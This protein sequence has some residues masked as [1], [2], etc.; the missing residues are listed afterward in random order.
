MEALSE[1][2]IDNKKLGFFSYVFNFDSENKDMILNMFQ[3]TFIALPF[4][5]LV[6]K[7][8]NYFTPEEDEEKKS[9]EI[10][11]EL[12]LT[13]TALLLSIWFINKIIMY[14]PTYSKTIYPEFNEITFILPFLI[15]LFTMQTKIGK[16]IN[17]LLERLIDLYEGRTNLR[18]NE[19]NKDIKTHQPIAQPPVHQNSQADLLPRQNNNVNNISNQHFNNQVTNEQ[20]RTDFNNMFAGPNT[21]LVNAQEP[22]AANE[23]IGGGIFGGSVF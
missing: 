6:L 7:I 14:I 8:I 12:I 21:P 5:L 16:K 23:A 17:I 4:V 13:I 11:V 15:L 19:K 22:M 2:N 3:Y 9:L 10:S 20:P 1:S 18:N